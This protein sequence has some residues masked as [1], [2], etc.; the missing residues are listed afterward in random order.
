DD[1]SA[2]DLPTIKAWA[3]VVRLTV[4]EYLGLDPALAGVDEMSRREKR[5]R[6]EL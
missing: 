6:G 2:L 1:A 5:D 3:L 4:A